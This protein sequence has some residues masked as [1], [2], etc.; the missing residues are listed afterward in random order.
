MR[1]NLTTLFLLLAV[2]LPSAVFAWRAMD[3]PEFATYM[4]TG[5]STYRLRVLPLG[6]VIASPACPKIPTRPSS[7]SVSCLFIC[8]L[9]I[10]PN[11]PDNLRLAT[12]ASWLCLAA[13]LAMAFLLYKD[14]GLNP[15]GAGGRWRCSGSI[16]IWSIRNPAVFRDPLYRP[17]VS[18]SDRGR[19]KGDRAILWAGALASAA[20][21]TRTPGSLWWRRNRLAA[22]AAGISTSKTLCPYHIA[23]Y[24]RVGLWTVTIAWSRSDESRSHVDYYTDYSD[25]SSPTSVSITF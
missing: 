4:M 3:M 12:I 24:F 7:S 19:R 9:A 15:P 8:Y 21:L 14:S 17:G 6:T 23:H 2:M 13:C 5:S 18:H 11:F 22:V 25:S 16:L 10:N 20:Y 1:R